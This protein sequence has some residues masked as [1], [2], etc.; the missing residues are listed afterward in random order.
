[1]ALLY[2]HLLES[3]CAV[4][5]IGDRKVLP[6]YGRTCEAGVDLTELG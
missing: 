5:H 2:V 6:D 4:V 1:M 3:V